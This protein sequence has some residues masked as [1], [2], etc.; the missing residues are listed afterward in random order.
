MLYI[1]SGEVP[2]LDAALR[3]TL[4]P[5]AL[6]TAIPYSPVEHWSAREGAAYFRAIGI[7]SRSLSRKRYQDPELLEQAILSSEAVYLSGGNTYEFLAYAERVGLF[8]MLQAFEANGGV[9]VAESA[10]SIILSPTIDTAAIPTRDADVNR[11]DLIR[12]QAMGRIPF[13]ISPHFE[14]GH[15]AAREDLEEL[16]ALAD[17]SLVPVIVLQDGEGFVMDGDEVVSFVG[18]RRMLQPASISQSLPA[19][20]RV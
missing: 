4:G 12:T 18:K 15:K 11:I 17:A 14:P 8:S 2:E 10:G 16:Q 5:R 9:I 1:Y 6:L 7:R 3:D 19:P 13:H 20:E